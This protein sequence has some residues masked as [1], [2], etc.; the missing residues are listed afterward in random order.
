MTKWHY[1]NFF[2][3]IILTPTTQSCRHEYIDRKY[4]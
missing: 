4:S 1:L 3:I 2:S